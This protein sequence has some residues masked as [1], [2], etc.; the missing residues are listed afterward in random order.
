MHH[1]HVYNIMH[2]S[3]HVH[4]VVHSVGFGYAYLIASKK[5][6]QVKQTHVHVYP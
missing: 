1:C 4:N 6:E 2:I 5:C 3:S